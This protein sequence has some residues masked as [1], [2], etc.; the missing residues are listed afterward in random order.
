MKYP[1]WPIYAT[2]EQKTELSNLAKNEIVL[3]PKHGAPPPL[4]NVKNCNIGKKGHAVFAEQRLQNAD[5]GISQ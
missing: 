5:L 2:S 4:N 1:K 3:R